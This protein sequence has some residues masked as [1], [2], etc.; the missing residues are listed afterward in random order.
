MAA[1]L[2]FGTF[3]WSLCRTLV[4]FERVIGLGEKT[5]QIGTA[6]IPVFDERDCSDA[7]FYEIRLTR[8]FR[9]LPDYLTRSSE[10]HVLMTFDTSYER[11]MSI[12]CRAIWA[13]SLELVIR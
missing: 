1:A 2:I 10:N 7:D 13:A 6:I 11:A 4:A 9:S 3:T 8:L 12:A 5:G